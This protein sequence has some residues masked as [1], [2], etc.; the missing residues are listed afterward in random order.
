M[1]AHGG[2]TMFVDDR[3]TWPRREMPPPRPLPSRRERV[4][5]RLL[6]GYA[7][8]LLLAPISLGGTVDLVRYLA[9]L[10]WR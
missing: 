7:L 4:M 10:V 9:A 1:N 5:S 3:S 2:R 8:I 6:L